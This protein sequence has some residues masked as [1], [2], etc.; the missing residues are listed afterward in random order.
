M[1]IEVLKKMEDYYTCWFNLLY[2]IHSRKISFKFCDQLS[3]TMIWSLLFGTSVGFL[4]STT[5]VKY[6]LFLARGSAF[7][8]FGGECEADVQ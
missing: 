7:L 4:D 6:L 3:G 2:I 5:R 1:S 8:G